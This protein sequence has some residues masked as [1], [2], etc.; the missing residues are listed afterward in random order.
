MPKKKRKGPTFTEEQKLAAKQRMESYWEKK[1]KQEMALIPIKRIL[2][3]VYL[4]GWKQNKAQ[5]INYRVDS[6]MSVVQAE[7]EIKKLFNEAFE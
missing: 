4:A 1:H 2:E 6:Q 5:E 3:A 7:R